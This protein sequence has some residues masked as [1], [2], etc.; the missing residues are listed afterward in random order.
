MRWMALVVSLSLAFGLDLNSIKNE[1]LN[2]ANQGGSIGQNTRNRAENIICTQ[3]GADCSYQ[4]QDPQ[5]FS[6]EAQA[7]QEYLNQANDPQSALGRALSTIWSTSDIKS[8]LFYQKAEELYQC[9]QVSPDGKCQMYVGESYYGECQTVQECVSQT[10]QQ[11]YAEYMCYIDTQGQTTGGETRHLCYVYNRIEP[12]VK[13]KE[14]VCH[15]INTESIRTCNKDLQLDWGRCEATCPP[16]SVLNNGRCETDVINATYSATAT[17]SWGGC[18]QTPEDPDDSGSLTNSASC[19]G[20]NCAVY[21]PL[22]VAADYSYDYTHRNWIGVKVEFTPQ[23]ARVYEAYGS[24]TCWNNTADCPINWGSLYY[25]CYTNFG[26]SCTFGGYAGC[27]MYQYLGFYSITVSV[28]A[29]FECP[30]RFTYDS[31]SGKCIKPA[32]IGCSLTNQTYASKTECYQNCY[33]EQIQDCQ[34]Q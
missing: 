24:Q 29:Q 1:S 13:E 26:R 30:V 20:L 27:S 21:I 4:G 12:T 23:G 7:R 28:Y 19:R 32:D 8:T 31:A 2:Y 22:V 11:T 17:I 16:N 14:Y 10:T 15:V 9:A 34:V 33:T 3:G 5:N 25:R 6:Q 18:A